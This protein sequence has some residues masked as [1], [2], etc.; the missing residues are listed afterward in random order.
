M[1]GSLGTSLSL[2]SAIRMQKVRGFLFALKIQTREKKTKQFYLTKK[3]YVKYRKYREKTPS[4]SHYFHHTAH[5][6]WRR[7]RTQASLGQEA[8]N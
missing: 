3:A 8:S 4:T 7:I 6:D 2:F 1:L 5:V